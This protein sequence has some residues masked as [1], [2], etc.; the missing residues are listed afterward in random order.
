MVFKVRAMDLQPVFTPLPDGSIFSTSV[1]RFAKPKARIG[2]WRLATSGAQLVSDYR[3]APGMGARAAGRAFHRLSQALC[4]SNR[5]RVHLDTAVPSGPCILVAN[6]QSYVDPVIVGSVVACL[7]IA[8]AEVTD[9]PIIGE[10]ARRYGSLFVEPSSV[11]SSYRLLRSALAQLGEGATLLNF[12]EGVTSTGRV[13]RFRKGVFG[14]AALSG[15]PIVPVAIA[16]G[17]KLI[18]KA[19]Q[20]AA[21]HYLTVMKQAPHDV[22][23]RFGKALPVAPD[24]SLLAR[25]AR[26]RI[27]LMLEELRVANGLAD[28]GRAATSEWH[29]QR[30]A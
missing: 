26:A 22:F 17:P 10:L 21:A 2:A 18:R 29:S 13:G 5:V 8:K 7:P 27:Q 4:L 14:L 11:G 6:H 1:G 24:A 30:F 20:S 23:L 12:P 3:W 28:Q 25:L 19:E 15:V 9:W 16:M